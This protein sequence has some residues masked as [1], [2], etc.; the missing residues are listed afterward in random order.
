MLQALDAA[1]AEVA[2]P[3]ALLDTTELVWA[4]NSQ[5]LC[6]TAAR[7]VAEELVTTGDVLSWLFSKAPGAQDLRLV[8]RDVLRATAALELLLAT[9]D[10]LASQA[11]VR[12]RGALAQSALWCPTHPGVHIECTPACRQRRRPCVA[13]G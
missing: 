4:C 8:D 10:T 2:I 11:E 13:C 12:L 3:S 5:R 9:F 1:G 7:L 6:L